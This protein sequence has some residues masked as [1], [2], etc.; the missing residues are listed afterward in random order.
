L[1]K[2][3]TKQEKAVL[4]SSHLMNEIQAVVEAKKNTLVFCGEEVK[5]KLYITNSS[6]M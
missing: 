6:N 3:L 2:E 1:T 4:A 5:F